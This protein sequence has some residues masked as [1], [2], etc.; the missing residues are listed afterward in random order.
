MN[1]LGERIAP[2]LLTLYLGKAGFSSQQTDEPLDPTGHDNLFAPIDHDRG[3]HGP[4]DGM[5]HAHSPQ[6]WLSR[7]R[8]AIAGALG[9]AAAVG[10]AARRS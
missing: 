5:A 3:A 10:L 1:V 9:G 2:W 7:H 4:F 6:A 8:G